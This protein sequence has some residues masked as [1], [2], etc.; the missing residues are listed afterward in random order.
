MAIIV[1][2]AL[3]GWE[4]RE[5]RLAQNKLINALLAKNAQDMKDFEM[6][7]K[8]KEIDTNPKLQVPSEFVALEDMSDEEFEKRVIREEN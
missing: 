3:L 8:I 4:K 5:A 2:G 6:V 7:D 1:L